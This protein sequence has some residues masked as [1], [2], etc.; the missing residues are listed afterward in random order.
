ME[1][2]T[3]WLEPGCSSTRG[4]SPDPTPCAAHVEHHKRLSW[5]SILTIPNE[6]RGLIDTPT[7]VCLQAAFCRVV[8]F[9][10]MAIENASPPP[11]RLNG[12]QTEHIYHPVVALFWHLHA[13]FLEETWIEIRLSIDF[14]GMIRPYI[15]GYLSLGRHRSLIR[16]PFSEKL[17]TNGQRFTCDGKSAVTCTSKWFCFTCA[18]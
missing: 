10:C 2:E 1:C 4:Y 8:L 12:C 13:P 16:H 9:R 17:R 5:W 3:S 15:D 18:N 14:P 6:T 11:F 7:M